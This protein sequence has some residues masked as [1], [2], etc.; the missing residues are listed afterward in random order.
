MEFRKLLAYAILTISLFIIYS[1]AILGYF[2]NIKEVEITN[3]IILSSL[4][5]NFLLMFVS[6]LIIMHILYGNALKNLYFVRNKVA[7][8]FLF[9]IILGFLFIFISVFLSLGYK[10]EN[11]LAEKLRNLH[12]SM[13]FLIPFFSSISEETFYRGF[14]Q[15]QLK[16][17]I[18]SIPAILI[19]S[20][21]FSLAHLE[22]GVTM[23]IILPFIFG[24]LLGVLMNKMEN[25][26]API[27]AHFTYNFISLLALFL[28]H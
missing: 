19:S 18:G 15:M 21:L 1:S 20:L 7:I 26:I 8:S 28:L 24:I 6:P 3:E 11:P 16:K 23:Q 17:K 12:I 5:L 10:E 27:S 2:M 14:L 4:L 13:L 22:Y 25:I 9:G